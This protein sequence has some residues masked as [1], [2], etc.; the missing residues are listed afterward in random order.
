MVDIIHGNADIHK[1]A[2]YAGGKYTKDISKYVIGWILG[3]EWDPE[4]VINTDKNNNEK[5][6]YEGKY[7][8]T[9]EASPFEAFLCETG[10]KV[11]EYE[12]QKYGMQR[13][14]S[15]TNWVTTDMLHHPNE[16]L[17]EKEDAVIVNTEHIKAKSA[18]K[19][20]LFASYHIYPYYPDFM[21]Y[22]KE[23]AN[24]K[25]EKGNINTY[26]AYL[27]DLRK[28]HTVPVLVA[29]FG[30]PASRGM[31]HVN[32]HTRFN[33]GFVDEVKQGKMLT[34]MLEDIY[35]E[36]YAGGLVFAWQDEW[37]KRTWNTMDLDIPDRRPY[38][39]NVQTNEQYFGLLS[40][41]PGLKKSICYVDG[42]ES[43]WQEKPVINE[44]GIKLYVKSD[45]RYVYFKVNVNNFDK[46]KQIIYIPIDIKGGQGNTK[47]NN[48]KIDFSRGIDFLIKIQGEDNSRILVD[49]YYDPFY[50]IYGVKL[51]MIERNCEY[52]V[53]NSGNFN[54]IYLC[55]NRPLYLS[56]D[57]VHLPLQKYETGKL[58]YG[59]ANPDSKEYIL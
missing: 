28:E 59:I 45:E 40:F 8:Y 33:Q 1:V 43:D 37:F 4:F 5:N 34:S 36:G 30:I 35:N 20:G 7:L 52:E 46:Q 42:D 9:K 55:L 47:A 14:L 22:Q 26:K 21:N 56:E 10:D 6:K 58:M 3:I 18:F 15:F 31:A 2:G 16:P 19:T 11:I 27:R 39:S 44:Q 49:S 32:V 50:Y 23:Y 51:N 54:P 38:W 12:T 13:P 48:E 17:P 29:E 25:D 41:D 24:F 57:K 53:K